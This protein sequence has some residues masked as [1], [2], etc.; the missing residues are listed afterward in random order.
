[1]SIGLYTN[2]HHKAVTLGSSSMNHVP[3]LHEGSRHRTHNIDHLNGLPVYVQADSHRPWQSNQEM[4][5][6]MLA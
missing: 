1:M 3:S 2:E 5:L 4:N 6:I